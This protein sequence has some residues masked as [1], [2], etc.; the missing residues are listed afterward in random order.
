MTPL[1]GKHLGVC[2]TVFTALALLLSSPVAAQAQT[3]EITISVKD[4]TGTGM[5]ASGKADNLASG[6]SRGFKTDS[7]GGYAI[8]ALPFGRYRLE[9][10]APGFT[11]QT[12]LVEVNSAKPVVKTIS[13]AI[14]AA[15]YKVDV[16]GVTPLGGVDLPVDQIPLPVQTLTR[17]DFEST[18]ALDLSDLMNRRLSGVNIN[19]TQGNPVQ[20]DVNYRGYT[21]SPL[22]G[23]PEGL[24]IYM[25]G[26]RLNQ[27]F[28]DVVSWDLIPRIA[29]SEVALI[30]G[31]NPLFGLNTL[32]GALSLQ[33]KSGASKPGTSVGVS[34][35]SFGRRAVEFDHGWANSKGLNWYAAGN[36]F[37]DDGWRQ[38]SPSDVRQAF[39]K[40]GWQGTKTSISLTG[41]YA[42]NELI[43]NGLQD[44]RLL[45]LDYKSA[46]TIPDRTN[47]RAP[48]LNLTLRHTPSTNLTLSGNVYFRYIRADTYNGDINEG[49]LDQSVYQPGAAERTALANAGYTGVPAAGATAANTPFPFWRCIGNVLLQ[50]EPGEKCNGLINRSY[51]KQH[52]YGLSGQATWLGRLGGARNQLTVGLAHDRS[53]VGFTQ[54]TELGYIN[55]DKTI[56]GMNVFADGVSAGEVDGEPFDSRVNLRGLIRTSSLF[57]ADTLQ[58]GSSLTLS[59]AGRFNANSVDNMDRIRPIAGTGSLTGQHDFKRLNPSLGF[60][61]SPKGAVSIYGS[62]AE[63]SRTPTSIELGCA[64]PEAPCKL[65]N[66]LAGD[67]PL[68]Q[69]VTRTLEAGVRSGQERRVSW[70]LGWFRGQNSNDILF[71]SST[72]TGFGYFKNFGKTRRQGLEAGLRTRVSRFTL[73]GNYTFLD[74]TF[75]SPEVVGAAGNSTND[76]ALQGLRGQEGVQQIQ[77]GNR[78]PL[79]PQHVFKAF[80][81]YQ[82]TSKLTVDLDFRAVSSSFARGN[83]NNLSKPDGTYYIG[84]G[85]SPGYGV[86]NLG[87]RYQV[88]KH[89]QAYVQV[90]NLLNRKYYTGAQ[91]GPTGFTAAGNFIARP[92]PAASNGEFPVV[93]TTFYAPAAPIGATAGIRVTF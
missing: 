2:T 32:G 74:A 25:D 34:G 26:V 50:D 24:S 69:V 87:A 9:V 57:A 82:A 45:A 56:K 81:D 92:F 16:V 58:L 1:Q 29:I 5:Q 15:N 20:P 71:V 84:Q 40:L 54:S 23:T 75:Q 42:D 8:T 48:F 72:A 4:A 52:N 17:K 43:G 18:A 6:V 64:D 89:L 67:P 90:N 27:P 70:N 59:F 33:T 73:G 14:G 91:L 22:L 62:Y 47:N 61:W 10:S 79:I 55:P 83:E 85:T 30:P 88:V 28:G 60:T 31:S 13:L 44:Q 37:H 86:L 3:G 46:Y 76:L 39:S 49:S 7:A 53:S 19:E 35:G 65:P 51:T 66:A 21:A 80:A 63:G 38:A 11:T 78:L 68:K 36:L 77:P 12:A 93:Q 41:S